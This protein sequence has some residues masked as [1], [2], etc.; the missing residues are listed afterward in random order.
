MKVPAKVSPVGLAASADGGGIDFRL[1]V[2]TDVIKT[3][4]A[5]N[6]AMNG[7][8]DDAAPAPAG[9]KPKSPRF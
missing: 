3:G 6:E 4:A 1:F 5:I 2:P 9:D 8:G 7:G